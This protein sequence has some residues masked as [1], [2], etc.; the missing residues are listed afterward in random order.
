MQVLQAFA[1]AEKRLKP[2][3]TEMFSEV[4]DEIPTDLRLV[5]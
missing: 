1:R 4:Y 5:N 3:W 2:K